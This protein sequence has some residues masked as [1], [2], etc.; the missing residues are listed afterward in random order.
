MSAGAESYILNNAPI[1]QLAEAI[2]LTQAG[3]FYLDLAIASLILEKVKQLQPE[4][5][6][7]AAELAVLEL[8][9][10]GTDYSAIASS[11]GITFDLVKTQISNIINR[12]Y[13]SKKKEKLKDKIIFQSLKAKIA[14]KRKEA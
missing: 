11:L 5:I 4:A 10:I 13:I 14:T 9:A 12:L 6:I 1:D 8:I 7:I 2:R 3:Y